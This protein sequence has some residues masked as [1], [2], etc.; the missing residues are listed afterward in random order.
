MT[1]TQVRQ[2]KKRKRKAQQIVAWTLIWAVELLAAAAQTALVAAIAIPVAFSQ[3]GYFAI[4]GEWLLIAIAFCGAF[5]L[6]HKQVC[7][8]IF[9]EGRG[10]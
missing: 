5:F 2:R 10:R 6:I 7:D 1:R 8:R 9:E 4:G 3:R